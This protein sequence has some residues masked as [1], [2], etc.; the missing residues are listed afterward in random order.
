MNAV[1]TKVVLLFSPP[2]CPFAPSIFS[3][4][5]P[6]HVVH[7]QPHLIWHVLSLVTS[8]NMPSNML[9]TPLYPPKVFIT[10]ITRTQN[11]PRHDKVKI[12]RA[13]KWADWRKKSQLYFCTD[14]SHF[15]ATVLYFPAPPCPVL[16]LGVFN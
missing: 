6:R 10:C 7:S 13:N 16:V 14:C 2:V 8:H 1:S 12:K 11:M 9:Y 15:L 3:Q 5:T 4:L